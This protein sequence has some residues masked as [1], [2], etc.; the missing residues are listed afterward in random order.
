V[1]VMVPAAPTDNSDRRV[2]V[3]FIAA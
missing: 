1:M 2:H 3:F